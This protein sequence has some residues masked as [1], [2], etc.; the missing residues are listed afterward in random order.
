MNRQTIK[1]F[2]AN[3][4][5]VGGRFEGTPILLLHHI[6]AK[7]GIER[8]SP[9]GYQV[10]IVG[11]VV[12]ATKGGAPTNPDWYHNLLANPAATVEIGTETVA[13]TARVARGAERTRMWRT[14]IARVPVFGE[15]EAT[16]GREIPVI[17]LQRSQ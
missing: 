8:I 13:V 15:Y 5:V 12:F 3:E 7:S 6:G 1:E 9:L 10:E 4:G 17:V 11:W 2:R 14:A 16:S